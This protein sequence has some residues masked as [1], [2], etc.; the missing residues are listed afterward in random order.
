MSATTYSYKVRD[1]AGKT[2]EG[3]LEAD[4]EELVRAKIREMGMTPVEIKKA[5]AGLQMEIR[6]P[7]LTDSVKL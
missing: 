2:V 6:I 7:G 4:N 3:T 5:G 1:K